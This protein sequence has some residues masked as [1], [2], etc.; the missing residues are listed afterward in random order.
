MVS[1]NTA[2]IPASVDTVEELV[3]WAT[4]I[5]EESVPNRQLTEAEN[6]TEFQVTLLTFKAMDGRWYRQVRA[7]IPLAQN[8][9]GL[10]GKTWQQAIP[11]VDSAIPLNY[12]P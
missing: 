6:R 8:W 4:G 12:L 11:I 10:T 7:S 2:N 1:L 9:Q 5:L 3:L